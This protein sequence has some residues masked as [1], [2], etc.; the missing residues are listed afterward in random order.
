MDGSAEPVRNSQVRSATFQKTCDGFGGYSGDMQTRGI[1]A[2]LLAVGLAHAA[3]DTQSFSLNDTKD[4]I[5]VNVKVDAVEYNGRKAVR[6][7]SDTGKDGFALLKDVDFQDGTIELDVALKV[8]TPPGVPMPGYFGVAFRARADASRYELFYLRPG[9]SHADDQ[10]MRNHSLQYVSEPEFSWYKLR[11][12]WPWVYETYGELQLETWMKVKI[13]VQGRTARLYLN[14]AEQPGLI[15]DGLKGTDLHGGIGLW[16]NPGE[17]AYF[18]NVRVSHATPLPIKN[19]SDA[20]G[21][22]Q[23]KFAADAGT[24]EGALQL[25]REGNGLTGTWSGAFGDHLPVQGTWRDGYIELSFDANWP[26][27]PFGNGGMAKA[28]LAGWV[29]GDEAGGRM[30]VAGRT[31]GHWT[32]SRGQDTAKDPFIGNWM[33]NASKSKAIDMMQVAVVGANRYAITFGPGATDTITA[34]GSDQPGLRGTTLSVAIEA[35]DRWKVVRKD[36]GR[37]LLTGIWR[38]SK[39][40]TTLSDEFTNETAKPPSTVTYAYKRTAGSS[41]FLGNW[42]N[43]NDTVNS[44]FELQVQSY[45]SDGLSLSTRGEGREMKFDGMEYPHHGPNVPAGATSSG[46]RAGERSL[47]IIDKIGSEVAVT[48]QLEI[49]PDLKTLT[50]TVHPAGQRRPNIFVFDRQQSDRQ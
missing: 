47:E 23:V 29:D 33:L 8:T 11:R 36:N 15:V 13:E 46:H 45:E 7:I 2:L 38:L 3:S 22:W 34:D 28:T 26:D 24:F 35:P 4:L 37:K 16:G 1:F 27:R 6:V 32:A 5:P 44:T 12:E 25:R 43:T 48:N 39:D 50:L 17:E 18:A 42:E 9:N 30:S 31:D 40:G 41:G 20:S 14:G 49:S 10:A 21:A 19:G